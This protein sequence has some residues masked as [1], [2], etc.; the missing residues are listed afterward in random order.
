L[1]LVAAGVLYPLFGITFRPELPGLAM[2]RSSVKVNTLSLLLK[3]Y[4]PPVRRGD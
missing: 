3:E 4:I 1:I 2:A